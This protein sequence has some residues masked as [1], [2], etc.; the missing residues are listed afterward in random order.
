MQ[1]GLLASTTPAARAV[2]LPYYATAVAATNMRRG[3]D[4]QNANRAFQAALHAGAI[5]RTK[6][7]LRALLAADGMGDVTPS[8]Q[9][10]PTGWDFYNPLAWANALNPGATS[11]EPPPQKSDSWWEAVLKTFSGQVGMGVGGWLSGQNPW[12]KPPVTV[13]QTD[14]GMPSWAKIALAG[15]GV[16]GG[17]FLITRLLKR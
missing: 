17:A 1:T 15:A 3:L 7:D 11:V 8:W 2:T 12:A 4:A 13:M 14:Q 10:P 5:D 9:G 6:I 16:V